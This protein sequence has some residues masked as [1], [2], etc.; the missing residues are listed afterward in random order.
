[1]IILNLF[2]TFLSFFTS[3]KTIALAE[4]KRQEVE[5]RQED[6]AKANSFTCEATWYG[7]YFHGKQTASGE[8]FDENEMTA[9]SNKFPFGTKIKM[10][11]GGNEVIVKINDRGAFTH[12]LDLSK[13]AFLQLAPLERGRIWGRCVVLND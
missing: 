4:E 13:A 9:A 12:D 2:F 6:E 8:I 3:L 5:K 7:G 1:M 10:T 11:Y